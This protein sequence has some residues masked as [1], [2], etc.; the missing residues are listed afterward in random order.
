MKSLG[1][2]LKKGI[3]APIRRDTLMNSPCDITCPQ[4][5]RGQVH[6][7]YHVKISTIVRVV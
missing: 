2:T 1:M 4:E 7:H 6:I 5:G 3:H